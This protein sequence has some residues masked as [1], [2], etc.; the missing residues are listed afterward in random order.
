M[1]PPPSAPA[2]ERTQRPITAYRQVDGE[3]QDR[4]GL[5]RR[6]VSITRQGML[7]ERLGLRPH[8]AATLASPV[9]VEAWA[10]LETRGL[11][12]GFSVRSG[13]VELALPPRAARPGR[14]DRLWEH[15]C[16]EAF[17]G[18]PDAEPY[19]E[20]NLSPSGDWALW[21]FDG[22]RSGMRAAASD[23]PRTRIL[24]QQGE[25]RI[26]AIVPL[27]A[28]AA[29]LGAPP[30]AVGLAA[31]IETADGKHAY[32]ALAHPESRP[33]FHARAARTLVLDRLRAP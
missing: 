5:S 19:A 25:L 16:C 7:P 29:V 17:V 26:D 27:D 10:Q 14:R 23:V 9:H 28:L 20:L 31:V 30:Y 33:D 32:F 12:L 21:A 2:P 3:D 1:P 6:R 11:V 18:T 4:P 13:E 15:T 24:H 22:Y 8:P